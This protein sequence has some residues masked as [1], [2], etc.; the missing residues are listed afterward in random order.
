MQDSGVWGVFSRPAGRHSLRD[1]G[2]R[3]SDR[4]VKAGFD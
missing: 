2:D 4:G 3:I 1:A